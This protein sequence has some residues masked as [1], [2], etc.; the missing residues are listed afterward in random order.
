MEVTKENRVALKKIVTSLRFLECQGLAI[1]GKDAVKRAHGRC[2][3]V[4]AIA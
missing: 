3:K 4:K 1:R 2:G